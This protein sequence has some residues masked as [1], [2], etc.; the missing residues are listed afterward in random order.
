VTLNAAAPSFHLFGTLAHRYD[1]H[2]PPHHYARDHDF[3][4]DHLE[5]AGR[6]RLLDVGCG[7]GVLLEKALARGFDAH[8]I[9]AAPAM[10]A[11]AAGKVGAGRVAVRAMEDIDDDGAF[12]GL[13]ALSWVI[14]Y[15]ADTM[16]AAGILRRMHRALAPG[17]R[18]L[19]QTA[20]APNMD[21]AVLEDRE[22]GPDGQADD[23]VFLFQFRPE[24]PDRALARYVYA[25]K[26]LG[27]LTWEEHP[28]AV[29]DAH[30][31]ARLAAEAGF[32]D[33]EIRGSFRGEPLGRSISPWIL[34]RRAGP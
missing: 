32:T 33:V 2:T 26:S 15:A 8:G 20:H 30:L 28:L 19:L 34:A 4:L 24:G 29:A 7:T 13:C 12:D 1:L 16:A 21:G 18:L 31:L 11:E 22:P 3:V 14:N 10:V 5:G 27:E 6:G 25:G 9:D 17:G 23:V